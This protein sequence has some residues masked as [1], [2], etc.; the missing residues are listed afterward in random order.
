[1]ARND[2]D[3]YSEL[4]DKYFLFLDEQMSLVHRKPDRYSAATL[5]EFMSLIQDIRTNRNET[6]AGSVADTSER[7][8]R[9]M[10]I[11]VQIWLTIHVQH[12]HSDH[13][14]NISSTQ[15]SWARDRRLDTSL[16]DL[17]AQRQDTKETRSRQ[18]PSSFSIPN[19]V[20]H[21]DFKVAWTSDLLQHLRIDW[22]SKQI[23]IFEHGICLRDHLEYDEISHPCPLPKAVIEEAVDTIRLLF[24]NSKETKRF[25]SREG[26]SF[27]KVPYGRGRRLSLGDYTY[28][29]QSVVDLINHWED[30]PKGWAQIRLNPD[31]GNLMEYATF[32]AATTVLILTTVSIM[33]GIASLVIAKQA[34]DISI[35]SY[36]LALAEAC[37]EA[38]ATDTLPGF[39]T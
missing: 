17:F 31:Q 23:T 11:A 28:W 18:I 22:K 7:S 35:K 25:L 34:L 10:D 8:L 19:L 2:F 30:G 4:Y 27:L 1:M 26:R 38:N 32:W 21:Y 13:S 12:S 36:N 6:K 39:C 14:G 15:F 5:E 9:S 3:T 37:A 29:R 24:P 33:F 16:E 20:H